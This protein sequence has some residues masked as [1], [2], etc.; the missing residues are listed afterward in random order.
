MIV[1][2]Q[3]R[4]KLKEHNRI[5]HD[6]ERH[7]CHHCNYEAKRK[8][9]LRHEES[10]HRGGEK[11]LCG[12]CDYSS[13]RGSDLK[14]H[15]ENIHIGEEHLCDQCEYSFNKVK[16]LFRHIM[17]KQEGV[18][19]PWYECSYST[20]IVRHKRLKVMLIRSTAH[21]SYC[22]S[23]LLPIRPTATSD[24]RQLFIFVLFEGYVR[25]RLFL[26]RALRLGRARGPGAA[27]RSPSSSCK[28]TCQQVGWAVGRMG[29]GQKLHHRC[30][31][32]LSGI[33]TR[34]CTF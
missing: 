23:A 31:E 14:R 18:N 1:I 2:F 4:K 12:Q 3:R 20:T 9:N 5:E 26:G 10:V 15:I 32:G 11:Y 21:P 34:A 30:Q 8:N 17:S 22:P 25:L 33:S 29:V 7:P 28:T 19:F 24:L 27:A 16:L 13:A 6:E